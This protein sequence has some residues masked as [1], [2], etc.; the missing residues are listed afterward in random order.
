MF[1][2]IS[3]PD[4]VIVQAFNCA[5]I[6]LARSSIPGKQKQKRLGGSSG[7]GAFGRGCPL[8]GRVRQF[9]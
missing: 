9:R 6:C 8:R 2:S 3:V 1:N 5:P 7:R 4:P